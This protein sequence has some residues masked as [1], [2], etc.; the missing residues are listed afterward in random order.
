MKKYIL[1]IAVL[2]TVQITNAQRVF[3]LHAVRVEGNTAAFE[4]AETEI[5]AKVAQEAVNKGDILYW[6]LFKVNKFNSGFDSGE[7]NYVWVQWSNSIDDLLSAKTNWWNNSDKVLTLA[8]IEQRKKLGATYKGV[9]D[10]RNIFVVEGE[11]YDNNG[12][13]AYYQLN[14]GRPASVSGFIQEN[15]ALWKPFFEKN[16]SKMNMK[17]WGVARRLTFPTLETSK[18]TV[19]SWDAFGSLEDLMKYRIGIDLPGYSEVIEKSKMTTYMPDGFTYAPIFKVLK[20]T[21][22]KK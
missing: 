7:Y 19:V 4:K 12:Y 2:C 15:K 11:A 21:T 1:I 17:V 3:S 5:N 10:E 6:G 22:P 20:A 13:P 9:K 8:E 18:S 16:M 14:F